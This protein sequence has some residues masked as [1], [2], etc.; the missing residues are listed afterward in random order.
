MS[1][2]QLDEFV[3]SHSYAYQNSRNQI[4]YT[5]ELKHSKL[6]DHKVFSSLDKYILQNKVDNQLEKWQEKWEKE[7]EKLQKYREKEAEKR[8]K[9][10]KLKEA[11][12][13]TLEAERKLKEVEDLLLFTLEVDDA[14]NWESVKDHRKYSKPKPQQPIKPKLKE[15]PVE[16]T[17][18]NVEF[19]P[20]LSFLDKIIPSLRRKKEEDAYKKFQESHRKWRESYH[21]INHAN[22]E[23]EHKY[24]NE[25]KQWEEEVRQWQAKGEEFYQLQKERNLRIDQ[26]RIDYQ[27]KEPNAIAEYCDIV[28]ANSIYPE[29]FPKNYEIEFNADNGILLIEYT[30][31]SIDD[32]P[33]LKE[34]KYIK[35]NDEFK[36]S[37]LSE[38]QIMK[39]Y[40]N[41]LYNVTLRTL[42]EVF[43]ADVVDGVDAI[44]LNGWVESINPATGIEERKC[45]LSINANKEEFLKINLA[46]V[47]PK[48]CFK[49]FKGVGSSKL[50]SLSP[51][52]PLMT[53][54]RED[55][56]FSE[57]Y[58]VTEGM[59]ES[60]NLATMGWEDF[61]HLIRELFEKEFN[62][63]GGEVRITQASRDGGV[64]AVAFDPDPIRGGKIVIQA[65]RYTNTVGVSAVR[66]LFGTVMN[67]GASKGI[68]VTT[69]DYGPDAYTFAKDKPLTLLNGS[70]L[71]YLLGKHGQKARIDIKEAKLK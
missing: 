36:E 16:P 3:T 5:V 20:V 57:H 8:D 14:V 27:N 25:V 38:N 70:N 71:L 22:K 66:D 21:E 4:K 55:K 59:D 7:Q 49:Q 13:A 30:L 40:D 56:R 62:Q 47:D 11:K 42:H 33:K 24:V 43:E 48:A 29:T 12:D 64:D 10:N 26:L 44:N 35:T 17:P 46:N 37:H 53:I 39:M 68:L 31:P 65:K 50:S 28:L 18:S 54:N 69:S 6:K 2:Q 32:M 19:K 15:Y 60:T 61:E 23:K 63:S 67:E 51:I 52:K 1:T 58:S 9:E 34:I 45:I 41:T